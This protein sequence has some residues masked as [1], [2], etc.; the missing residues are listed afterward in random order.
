MSQRLRIVTLNFWGT[1]SPLSQRLALAEKQLR[2]LNVDVV[3]MQEVRPLDGRAGRT[4][5]HVLADAL[6]MTATYEVAIAWADGGFG[7]GTSGGQEGLAILSRYPVLQHLAIKLPEARPTE[8][9]I[10]LSAQ[11]DTPAGELWVHTTHLH[12]R[13]DDGMAREQQVL[14]I[15]EAVRQSGRSNDDALF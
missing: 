1:E 8:A 9:R 14:A 11:L 6:G 7:A 2:A 3:C 13:L 4:T 15:D 12:Y 5:A 10:L